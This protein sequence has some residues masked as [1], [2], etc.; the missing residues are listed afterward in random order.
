[1][2]VYGMAIMTKAVFSTYL[3]TWLVLSA[4]VIFLF[5]LKGVIVLLIGIVLRYELT[6]IGVIK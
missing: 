3:M 2:L 4:L 1:M 6:I 5:L